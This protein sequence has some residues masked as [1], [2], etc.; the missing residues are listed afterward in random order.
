MP[1]LASGIACLGP[2]TLASAALI[3]SIVANSRCHLVDYSADEEDDTRLDQ[4]LNPS[5]FGLWC[6]EAQNGD[7]YDTRDYDFDSK[8]E[9]AR[10]LGTTVIVLGWII[11]SFYLLA[12]CKRFP[13][14]IFMLIGFL[15]ICT[16][17][18][19][20]LVFLVYK[21]YPC[22]DDA[23]SLGTGGRCAISATVFWFF[24]G[25]MSCASGKKAEEAAPEAQQED[26]KHDITD[27]AQQEED[28]TEE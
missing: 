9:A 20:G 19:Q 10:G 5:S 13:P 14:K 28:E 21:S 8:F 17:L 4:F 1:N 26:E 22:D 15:C 7:K 25:T 12:S 3:L 23:C 27:G 6:Y 18:F 2:S 24:A 16:S 11:W